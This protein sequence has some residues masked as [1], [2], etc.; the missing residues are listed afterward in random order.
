M[1]TIGLLLALLSC[2]LQTNAA[3]I[4]QCREPQGYV[5]LEGP[6]VPKG[7]IGWTQ[8]KTTGG[9]YLLLKDGENFDVIFSDATK[10]TISS[11][12]DGGQV[13]RITESDGTYV[14]L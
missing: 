8:D 4:T 14:I 13:I 10:R 11:R 6:L 9:A 2:T 12:E 3:V 7:K 5:Y 1:R